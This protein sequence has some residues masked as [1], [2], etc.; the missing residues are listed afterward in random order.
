MK[1]FFVNILLVYFIVPVYSQVGL[2]FAKNFPA[3]GTTN[4]ISSMVRDDFGNTYI[5]GNFE[6]TLNFN[7]G[8]TPIVYTSWSGVY[9]GPD[10]FLVKYDSSWNVKWVR[11]FGGPG[12]ELSASVLCNGTSV[13]IAGTFGDTTDFDPG[14]DT[15]FVISAGGNDFFLMKF[16]S[17]GN[18]NWHQTVG[19]GSNDE[20][21]DAAIIQ[22]QIYLVGLFTTTVDFDPG[23]GIFNLTDIGGADG[24]F[25]KYDFSGNF[26]NAGQIGGSGNDDIRSISSINSS[27]FVI[28]GGFTAT[29]VFDPSGLD[30]TLVSTGGVDVFFAKVDTSFNFSWVRHLTGVG[31]GTQYVFDSDVNSNGNIY[32]A[33]RFASAV[34]FDPGPL[35]YSISSS[36]GNDGF[37]A[38]YDSL[39]NFLWASK[40][41]G[42]ASQT[43]SGISANNVDQ[44][45]VTGFFGGITDF[46]NS[47]AT[48]NLD[49]GSGWEIF[50]MKYSHEGD[51]IWTE[52]VKGDPGISF[53]NA[54]GI[55]VENN[56]LYFYG[57]YY[58]VLHIDP[59]NPGVTINGIATSYES[60]FLVKWQEDSCDLYTTVDS[61]RQIICSSPIGYIGL[62]TYD[63]TEPYSYNWN[64]SPVV[65]DSIIQ[66]YDP[67]IYTCTI[68]DSFWCSTTKTFVIGGPDS[69]L[70]GVFDLKEFLSAGPFRTGLSTDLKYKGLNSG[71]DP[72]NGQMRMVLDTM[73]IYNYASIAPNFISGDTLIWNFTGM[74]FD[75]VLLNITVN[76]TTPT[77]I[78]AGY[79]PCFHTYITPASGDLDPVNNNHVF[80]Y[81]VVNSYDP[82]EKQAFPQ[83]ECTQAYILKN[84][85]ISYNIDFQNTGTAPALNISI[86]D[87]LDASLDINSL[88]VIGSSHYAYTEIL[89]GNV[90]QFNFPD[91]NLADS[92]SN[93][94]MSHG[95]ILYEVTPFATEP[96]NE[97]IKNAASIYFDFNSPVVTNTVTHTLIDTI[98]VSYSFISQTD[99][100]SF[101]FNNQTYFITGIYTQTITNTVG[102]DSIITLD[103]TIENSPDTTITQSFNQLTAAPGF[104]YQWLD[105]NSGSSIIPGQTS[106]TFTAT[107]NGLYAAAISN[108]TCIDTSSCYLVTGLN[109]NTLNLPSDFF[110]YP[111]PTNS[112]VSIISYKDIADKIILTDCFGRILD[113]IN[114]T[115]SKTYVSL[116]QF[117]RGVY[118]VSILKKE[119]PTISFKVIKQ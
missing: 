49:G 14:P 32:F 67:G 18:Y 82:N 52:H 108:G 69:S 77:W 41:G 38:A 57:G 68:L 47:A 104:T 64:S 54:E 109:N 58:S 65:N 31:A 6:G 87:T 28:S 85:L 46:D 12:T 25:A 93:E 97:I 35:S 1:A 117:E 116:S 101:E 44:A 73:A 48:Y 94:A 16:D 80:C 22:N 106:Q 81:V 30:S 60:S 34:D 26:I 2:D 102:C 79:E 33:G 27:H 98:P 50:V 56:D 55:L 100:N 63:G 3:T 90:L 40:V 61:V 66:I 86:I 84:D 13:F 43:S 83:G 96:N 62:N 4:K 71:C 118:Y 11:T 29:A 23:P 74:V 17:A 39:G 115:H 95:F 15:N 51:M 113:D 21:W 92:T 75:S 89:P 59:V 45:F 19:G 88:N 72:I 105:C 53:D 5:T 10:L 9:L 37:A 20:V 119:N 8:G 91:I 42:T 114:P 70:L 99:C 76:I 110:L 103:L 107:V 7:I 36:G 111:N 112:D 78:L 24:F